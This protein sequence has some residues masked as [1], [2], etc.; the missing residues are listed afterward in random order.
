MKIAFDHEA[1]HQGHPADAMTPEAGPFEWIG[2]RARLFV[3]HEIRTVLNV[4]HARALARLQGS[5]EP[6]AAHAISAYGEDS[7]SVNLNASSNGKSGVSTSDLGAVPP[8]P[9]HEGK[10]D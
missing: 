5:F 4:H 6:H 3:P 8:C 7:M 10:D 2:L 9:A 1:R